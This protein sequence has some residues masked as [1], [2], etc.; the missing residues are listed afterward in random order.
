MTPAMLSADYWIAR[1]PNPDQRILSPEEIETKSLPAA[2][3]LS[4]PDL[5]SPETRW[6]ICCAESGIF[7][8]P[9]RKQT[10]DEED[11][12]SDENRFSG[13]LVNEP[14]WILET[15]ADG[16]WFRIRTCFGSGWV[17]RRFIAVCRS[18]RE[19]LDAQ[20]PDSL[21]LVVTAGRLTLL[22]QR[23]APQKEPASYRM[24]TCLRLI[25]ALQA[26]K[27]ID[28]RFYLDNY[29]VR[30]PAR[31]P[32]GFLS[33]DYQLIPVSADVH[34]GFLPYTRRQLLCQIF[35]LQGDIYGWGDMYR[36]HD[37]SSYAMA[38]YRCF[39][40]RLARDSSD[41]A[42]MPFPS[43]DL[44]GL[45]TAEKKSGSPA[46]RPPEASSGS[47][48]ISCSISA[49]RMTATTASAPQDDAACTAGS[50]AVSAG[51]AF[52][53]ELG[54]IC[55]KNGRSWLSELQKVLEPR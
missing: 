50:P 49:G 32:D 39:G 10:K 2:S 19:W 22:P 4:F 18:R 37:C 55:R 5:Q 1:Q 45:K 14:V 53:C 43:I 11:P 33:W 13:I 8:H 3:R 30:I 12:W 36:S 26:P 46:A 34:I 44:K 48:D 54:S 24:G 16:Q 38:V 40:F 29:V 20:D 27:T 21:F 6:G 17:Q 52:L 15:S 7:Y 35:K 31:D 51:T 47:R 42:R 25:P 28:G 41:Q 23:T 9:T